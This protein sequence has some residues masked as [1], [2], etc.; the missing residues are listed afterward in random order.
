VV[1]AA[2]DLPR[3]VQYKGELDLVTEC[4]AMHACS[5]RS[6]CTPRRYRCLA[7]TR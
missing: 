3:N 5:R 7:A 6:A 2:L 1:R 4:V